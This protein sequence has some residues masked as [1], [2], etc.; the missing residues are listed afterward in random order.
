MSQIQNYL[1]PI[2]IK[3]YWNTGTPL[4]CVSNGCF[5]TTAAELKGLRWTQ[6][7]T[8]T[9]IGPLTFYRKGFLTSVLHFKLISVCVCVCVFLFIMCVHVYMQVYMFVGTHVWTHEQVHAHV[10]GN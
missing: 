7:S 10:R 1:L 3:S 2:G 9:K 5:H 8:Y 6:W 4:I